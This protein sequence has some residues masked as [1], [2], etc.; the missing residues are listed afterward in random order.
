MYSIYKTTPMGLATLQ[1]FEQGAW[2]HVVAPDESEIRFLSEE[3]DIDRDFLM[4]ALDEEERAHI[5]NDDGQT[6]IV[7]DVP[8]VSDDGSYATIPL[9]IILVGHYIVTV[10]LQERTLLQDFIN[11]KVKNF[12][13]QYRTRF[14]LRILYRNATKFLFYLKKIDKRSNEVEQSLHQ[15]TKNKEL[16]EMLK[17]EKALVY[18]STSLKS[19]EVILERLMRHDYIKNYPEDAE[20][21]ED[22]I[23]ENKQAIEMANIYT[24]ILSGTM[25]AFASIISNNLNLIMRFLASVT[26]V[27]SIPTLVASFFGMNVDMPFNVKSGPWFIYIFV[28]SIILSTIVGIFFYKNDW[29]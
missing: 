2:I 13:T 12:L 19:N 10:C 22:A 4:T 7:V 25:D 29:F 11:G 14:V 24:S 20:L 1:E 18:F 15:A 9:S 16:I 21:L 3:L 23:I 6:M 8:F 27:L 26:I 5:E 17:L 28:G